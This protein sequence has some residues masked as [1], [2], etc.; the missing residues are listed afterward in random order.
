VG[1]CTVTPKGPVQVL[2]RPGDMPY[3]WRFDGF[4]TGV[5]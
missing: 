5:R 2:Y 3:T 1:W 4:D